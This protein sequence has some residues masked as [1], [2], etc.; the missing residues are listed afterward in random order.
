[1]DKCLLKKRVFDSIDRRYAVSF[2]ESLVRLPSHNFS[3]TYAQK[4]V[5][6]KLVALGFE[7]DVFPCETDALFHL[8]DYCSFP[9]NEQ[10]FPLVQNVVGVKRGAGER[11]GS[12]LMLHAHIDSAEPCEITP[13]TRTETIDGRLYGLGVADDKCGVA[14][15]V[16]AAESVLKFVPELSGKLTLMSTIGKRGAVGTLTA[17]RRGYGGDGAVYIHPAET[18]HGLHEIKSYSMGVVE[19]KVTVKGRQGR[20]HDEIDNSE[21]NAIECG[22]RVIQAV[23]EWDTQRREKH[24]FSPGEGSFA[25]LPCTKADIIG[26]SFG[27]RILEDVLRF[28]FTVQVNFGTDETF[29]SVMEDL[30]VWLSNEF[31]DDPWLSENPPELSLGARKATPVKVNS[32]EKIIR[33]LEKNITEVK[34]FD[35]FIYQYHGASDIRMPIIYGNTPTVG[36]GTLCGGLRA[37]IEKEWVD[38]EDFIA[39]IKV[40]SGLILDWCL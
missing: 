16:L 25:G 30:R 9:G 35:D 40:V 23:R 6:S 12:S 1:M 14:I 4:L 2:L 10:Y 8:P 28:E 24:L 17:C 31:S 21:V 15:M 37:G 5:I 3:P 32:D 29:T 22:C 27:D 36:I 7:V 34:G 20:F 39:G 13:D 18:G 26:C 33:L 19:I 38:I 11:P